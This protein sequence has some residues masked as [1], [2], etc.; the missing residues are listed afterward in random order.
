MVLLA[1]P[2]GGWVV[3]LRL[4]RDVGVRGWP[5]RRPPWLVPVAGV[6][7]GVAVA[8]SRLPMLIVGATA[9]GATVFVARQLRIARAR[10]AAADRR[11]AAIGALDLMSAELRAGILPG[12]A[13]AAQA[14]EVPVLRP[15]AVAADHG[16]DVVAALLTASRQPGAEAL[17]DLA[18]AWHVAERA[19]APL[20]RVL[21]RVARAVREDAEVEREVAAEAAP[22]RATGRLMA[23]LP[24]LGLG[25]GAGLGA[26]PLHVLTGTVPGA[27]CLAAGVALAG[28]G[29]GWVDRIV[30]SAGA[31]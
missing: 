20:A 15:A 3:R 13:L 21:D 25:L 2:P 11:A 5:V 31:P 14:G 16:G 23:V 26:D 28:V 24:L 6:A 22:A 4:D 8:S 30:T 19:G 27:L 29:V 9:V 1:R 17:A 18:G 10:S 12:A 7:C